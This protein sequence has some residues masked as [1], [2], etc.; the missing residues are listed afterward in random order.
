MTN[1]FKGTLR[2]VDLIYTNSD[3]D[4]S[5]SSSSISVANPSDSYLTQ[6][7]TPISVA[8]PSDSYLTQIHHHLRLVH[9]AHNLKELDISRSRWGFHETDNGL[10]QIASARCVS[11]LSS[12]SLW[13]MTTITDSGVVQLVSRTSS[14]QH[15]PSSQTL[16]VVPLSRTQQATN[17]LNE[18]INHQLSS[19]I[20]HRRQLCLRI[21]RLRQVRLLLRVM[22][23]LF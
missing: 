12:I 22:W 11:N 20:L 6:T 17:H 23:F 5:S 16:P 15:L 2:I 3:N 1:P 14:L 19:L 7:L 18:N 9:L 4:S 10:Y 8:N 21:Y 13:G